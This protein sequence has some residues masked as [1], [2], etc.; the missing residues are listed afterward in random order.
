MTDGNTG[1]HANSLIRIHFVVGK[2]ENGVD[3]EVTF[4]VEREVKFKRLVE[5]P[6][7]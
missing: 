1:I 5:M 6:V 4:I 3:L 2:L 7:N